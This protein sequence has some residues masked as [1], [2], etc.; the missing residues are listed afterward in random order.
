MSD[1]EPIP[2]DR[3]QLRHLEDAREMWERYEFFL[4]L[5]EKFRGAMGWKKVGAHEY[6]TTYFTNPTTGKK[7]MGSLG[8]R[9][10]RPRRRR[11]TSIWAGPR[12]TKPQP[13]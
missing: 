8:R 13:K 7:Q 10:L 1:L 11:S 9:S 3:T 4:T 6:L 12:S 5:Q 2:M